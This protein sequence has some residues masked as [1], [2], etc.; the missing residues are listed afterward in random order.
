MSTHPG[1]HPTRTPTPVLL[2]LCTVRVAQARAP[3]HTGPEYICLLLSVTVCYCW[4]L[5]VTV[6]YHRHARLSTKEPEYIDDDDASAVTQ[7]S[8]AVTQSSAAVTQSS[9]GPWR[10]RVTG[11]NRQ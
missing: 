8:A 6:C 11:S 4:L 7:S 5:S 3:L 1:H 10:A 2:T 9:S